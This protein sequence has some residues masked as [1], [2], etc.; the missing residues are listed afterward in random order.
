MRFPDIFRILFFI[1]SATPASWLLFL[2][3]TSGLGANPVE[4]IIHT[5]GDWALN[6]L[7]ITLMI[8]PL[9]RLT[10]W[11]WPARLRRM[12]GLFCFFY[13]CLHFLA[14]LVLDQGLS[15]SAVSE[16]VIKHKRIAAGL[17]GLALLIPPAVTSMDSIKQRLGFRKWKKLQWAVYAAAVCGVVHYLWL[18]KR[19]MR[20][21][22]I[23]A[24]VLCLLFGYRVAVYL[25][26][27]EKRRHRGT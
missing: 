6:L 14:Y 17:A 23:Y 18:V 26:V 13:A 27:G 15:L 2:S 19:D 9:C 12:L 10:G 20:R 4:K 25:L 1:G 11:S 7:M 24:V 22:F 3:F 8:T 16:D 5:T 21:P